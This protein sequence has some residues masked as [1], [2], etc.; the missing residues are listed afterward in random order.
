MIR[1]PWI[2]GWAVSPSEKPLLFFIWKK[3]NRHGKEECKRAQDNISK[4]GGERGRKMAG[5]CSSSSSSSK[6]AAHQKCW[7]KQVDDNLKRLH[8][9]LFGLD[10]ALDNRDFHSA[11]ILGLRLLGFLHSQNHS[12]LDEA[13]IRPIRRDVFAKIH[14][15]RRSLIPDSDRYHFYTSLPSNLWN[16]MFYSLITLNQLIR[17]LIFH[18]DLISYSDS[19]IWYFVFFFTRKP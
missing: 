14:T 3:R 8:S 6:M 1:A 9:L 15:A 12:D 17:S 2:M 13:Y 16:S 10:L 4:R 11:Y 18:G 5:D 19:V 7:R